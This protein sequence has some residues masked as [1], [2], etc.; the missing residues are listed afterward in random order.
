ML[1][2]KIK[3]F[4]SILLLS[5]SLLLIT[6]PV[7]LTSSLYADALFKVKQTS[8]K[9]VE[10]NLTAMSVTIDIQGSPLQL[11]VESATII[12]KNNKK[13]S[14]ADI[15]PGNHIKVKYTEF[16]G[17]NEAKSILITSH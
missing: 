13:L 7:F 5:V 11:H 9:V 2:I 14:I 4:F 15:Q 12:T 17:I 8:G 3:R 16:K 1:I 10:V 6:P